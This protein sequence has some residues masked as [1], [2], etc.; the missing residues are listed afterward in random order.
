MNIGIVSKDP[1]DYVKVALA[2]ETL[3]YHNKNYLCHDLAANGC[4]FSEEIQGLL[5]EAVKTSGDK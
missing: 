4:K 2:L 5:K 3:A 1:M